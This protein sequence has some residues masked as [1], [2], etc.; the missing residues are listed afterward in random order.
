ML[1]KYWEGLK[2]EGGQ[3]FFTSKHPT[4]KTEGGFDA[5]TY[6]L[7]D[8]KEYVLWEELPE[9]QR[10]AMITI[11]RRR[12]KESDDRAE[13]DTRRSVERQGE[14]NKPTR[15]K[16]D[17]Y[18]MNLID[19]AE[20][21]PRSFYV[22]QACFRGYVSGGYTSYGISQ[23]DSW[24]GKQIR[25]IGTSESKYTVKELTRLI[26]CNENLHDV[27]KSNLMSNLKNYKNSLQEA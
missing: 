16:P 9:K 8:S 21:G 23:I 25:K 1:N 14:K 2:E 19:K 24:F 17:S 10:N 20:H 11:D 5:T 18:Y 22:D 4:K 6:R 27:I 12:K 15:L 13:E 26:L 3:D 7:E